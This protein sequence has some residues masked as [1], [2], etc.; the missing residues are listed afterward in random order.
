[1]RRSDILKEMAKRLSARDDIDRLTRLLQEMPPADA[2]HVVAELP[3]EQAVEVLNRLPA[4]HAAD[5]LA[6]VEP[7]L[8]QELLSRFEP[9][10]IVDVVEEM[11]SDEAADVLQDMEPQQAE[12]V[13]ADLTPELRDDLRELVQYERD[14]AGGIMAKEFAAVPADVSAGEAIELLRQN[15]QEVEDLN[16]V[17]A[18]DHE[19]RLV[20]NCSLRDIVLADPSTPISALVERH[21]HWVQ[22][23][24]DREEVAMYMLRHGLD[25]VPVVDAQ[26]RVIGQITLDDAADVVE[27]EAS[28]D[29]QRVSGIAGDEHPFSP[30]VASL[31][32]RVPWLLINIPL[33]MLAAGVARF[34]S[35]TITAVPRVVAYLPIIGG[36]A[37][38]AAGQ[39]IA[40]FVRGI[41]TGEV[42]FHDIWRSTAG[43][44]AR[45]VAVGVILAAV[46]GMVAYI[47]EGTLTYVLVVGVALTLNC[48]TACVVG[49]ALPLLLR[50]LGWDPA[51]GS[52]LV[53]TSI[54]DA[55]GYAFLLGTMHL[56]W[57]MGLLR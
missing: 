49:S 39:T 9:D 8:R 19:G 15:F 43:Q 30:F 37:G 26:H 6:E 51:M 22:E 31:A 5:I 33:A 1:M 48:I 24:Q 10:E 11:E 18:V 14:T 23:H 56:V 13:L 17:F 35:D 7:E 54:T 28:E 2:G 41:A 21:E 47:W 40:V 42:E 25:A 16:V 36:V 38:N 50:R 32:R 52:N 57:K 45:G 27:E 55:T 29:L 53:T 46:L 3:A 34:F 12:E 4:E 44:A 20:G